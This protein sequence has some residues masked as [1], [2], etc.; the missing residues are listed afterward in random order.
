MLR[1]FQEDP[2]LSHQMYDPKI[3]DF[4]DFGGWPFEPILFILGVL[5]LNLPLDTL[6]WGRKW[7]QCSEGSSGPRLD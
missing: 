2:P 5:V 4:D 1:P 7:D 3:G 6:F